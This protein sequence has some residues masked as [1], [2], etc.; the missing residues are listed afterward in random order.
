MHILTLHQQRS[1]EATS[2]NGSQSGPATTKFSNHILA[3]IIQMGHER[4]SHVNAQLQ[5]DSIKRQLID[6]LPNVWLKHINNYI[7]NQQHWQTATHLVNWQQQLNIE[8]KSA[9]IGLHHIVPT[10][11]RITQLGF[12]QLNVIV[13][14]KNGLVTGREACGGSVRATLGSAG[15]KPNTTSEAIASRDRENSRLLIHSITYMHITYRSVLIH[16]QREL[17]RRS[18]RSHQTTLS[19]MYSITLPIKSI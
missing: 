16:I 19:P 6:D 12:V 11:K 2:T 15:Y 14:A 18:W 13:T 5:L 9:S 10:W 4:I 8:S 1:R 3:N 7:V 17:D